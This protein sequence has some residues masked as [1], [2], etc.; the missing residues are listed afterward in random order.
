MKVFNHI[1]ISIVIF[2]VAIGGS[3]PKYAVA[4]SSE[5]V[6][7]NAIKQK[8]KETDFGSRGANIAKPIIIRIA[9]PELIKTIKD[10]NQGNISQEDIPDRIQTDIS[11]H[12]FFV[13]NPFNIPINKEKV[14]AK[15]A[16]EIKPLL[17]K[18]CK[19]VS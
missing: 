13:N 3:L 1:A 10:V 5:Q 9:E 18:E 7:R 11:N 2:G 19:G 12:S 6:C 4:A 17:K 8:L 16:G 15:V 14:S